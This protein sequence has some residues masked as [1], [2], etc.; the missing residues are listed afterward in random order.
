MIKTFGFLDESGNLSL[1]HKDKYFAVGAI[2]HPWPDELIIKLHNI[3]AGF[4]AEM[5]KDP[6]RL[7]LKFNEVTKR[8]LPFYIKALQELESDKD[9]RYCSLV[10]NKKDPKFWIPDDKLKQWDVI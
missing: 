2:F 8:A 9:W 1:R 10:V 7:E 4:S 3:F 5:K 6:T